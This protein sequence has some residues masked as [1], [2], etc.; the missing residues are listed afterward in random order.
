M[1]KK[2][3]VRKNTITVEGKE[4]DSS[5]LSDAARSH[6]KDIDFVSTQLQQKNNELQIA[7]TA[8]LM[9]SSVLKQEITNS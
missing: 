6:L 4:Y 1:A 9:Y 2:K 3:K 7:D 5:N 8:R